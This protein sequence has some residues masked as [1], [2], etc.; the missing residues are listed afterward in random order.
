M[1]GNESRASREEITDILEVREDSGG[2]G[3]GGWEQL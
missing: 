1:D 2:R 3:T